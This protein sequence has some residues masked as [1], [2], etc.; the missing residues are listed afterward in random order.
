VK[1]QGIFGVIKS[2]SGSSEKER[3]YNLEARVVRSVVKVHPRSPIFNRG[4]SMFFLI[5]FITYWTASAFLCC[6]IRDHNYT[7]A[8]RA[9]EAWKTEDILWI[10]LLAWFVLPCYLYLYF[11]KGEFRVQP[12]VQSGP[13]RD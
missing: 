8:G 13:W 6:V 5:L 10:V 1:R 11:V 7:A 4:V 12:P 9:D 2:R 3:Y